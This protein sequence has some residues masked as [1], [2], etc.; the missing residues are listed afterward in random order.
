MGSDGLMKSLEGWHPGSFA[1]SVAFGVMNAE[2]GQNMIRAHAL[3]ESQ[4]GP[5]VAVVHSTGCS[6]RAINDYYQSQE[7]ATS[8]SMEFSRIRHMSMLPLGLR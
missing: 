7:V 6:D 2:P 1:L 8:T 5:K 3:W 4:V